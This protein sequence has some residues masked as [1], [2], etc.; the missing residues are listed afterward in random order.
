MRKEQRAN[1]TVN[2]LAV[3]RQTKRILLTLGR[4]P[5]PRGCCTLLKYALSRALSA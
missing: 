3:K 1:A 4:A 5:E 2:A